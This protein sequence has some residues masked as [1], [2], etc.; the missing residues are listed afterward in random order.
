MGSHQDLDRLFP[1]LEGQ[2]PRAVSSLY[3]RMLARVFKSGHTGATFGGVGAFDSALWDLKAKLAGE[4]LWRLLGGARPVRARLRLGARHRPRRR[5]A[6]RPST[7][8]W[9]TA[10]SRA[11]SSRAGGMSR[12]TSAD[13]RSW[14]THCAATPRAPPSCST[15]TSRG[16]SSRP[17]GTSPRSRSSVDLTWIEEPLRRWDAAGHARLS[18]SVRAAV[19]TG[20]NLTG[21]RAVPAA[22][23]TRAPSTSCRRAPCGASPTSCASRSRPTDATCRSAR[24]D[25]PPTT[26]IARGGRRGAQPPLRRGAGPR[27]PVRR[28]PRPGVRRRRHRARRCAGRG[29]HDRRGGDR[30]APASPPRGSLPRDRTCGRAAR[31]CGSSRTRAGRHDAAAT[32]TSPHPGAAGRALHRDVPASRARTVHCCSTPGSTRASTG[33]LLPVPRRRSAST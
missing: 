25:S 24:W 7:R 11:A 6:R 10:A 22:A 18:A 30:R 14:R 17:C 31:G 27:R 3:D 2:D 23:S 1:A 8:R 4:P 13:S 26:P 9:P 5:A 20:E 19:A 28:H 15:R 16:T 32:R 33:T 29:H 21:P 12:T